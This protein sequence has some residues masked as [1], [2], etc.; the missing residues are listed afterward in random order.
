[1]LSITGLSDYIQFLKNTGQDTKT[2]ELTYWRKIIAT[3]FNQRD[4]AVGTFIHFRAFTQRYLRR[5]SDNRYLLW[6]LCF[7]LD[8]VFGPLSLVYN[9]PAVYRCIGTKYLFAAIIW[10]LMAHKRH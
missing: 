1:M 4:D 8:Q 5:A 10:W 2:F 6:F 7:M 9:I 3:D